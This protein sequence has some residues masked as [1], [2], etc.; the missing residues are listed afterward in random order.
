MGKWSARGEDF[1]EQLAADPFLGVNE[2]I[3][4]QGRQAED[5]RSTFDDVGV[6]WFQRGV[7]G[8][9]QCAEE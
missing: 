8:E 6:V 4:L 5:L 1:A 3:L 7:P 2:G 9:D